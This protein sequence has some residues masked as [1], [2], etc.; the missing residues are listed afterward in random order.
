MEQDE[1]SSWT[2]ISRHA[3]ITMAQETMQMIFCIKN[4][5]EKNGFK[6]NSFKASINFKKEVL[7]KNVLAAKPLSLVLGSH[8]TFSFEK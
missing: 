6:K 2:K 7:E 4:A 5:R 1:F 3:V 8:Q